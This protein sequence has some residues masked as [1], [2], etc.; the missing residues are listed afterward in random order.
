MRNTKTKYLLTFHIYIKGKYFFFIIIIQGFCRPSKKVT[1]K[2]E[3][4]GSPKALVGRPLKNILLLL[5]LGR[6][7]IKW[8]FWL[9]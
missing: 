6:K 1:T 5:P 7:V 3:E 4:V 9:F 8:F 2:L